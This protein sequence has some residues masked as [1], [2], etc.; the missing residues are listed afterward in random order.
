MAGHSK[1]ANIQHRKGRQDEKR[2]KVWT[3]VIREIKNAETPARRMHFAAFIAVVE[4]LPVATADVPGPAV[5]TSPP[6][7]QAP[8]TTPS[9]TPPP[10]ASR[11]RRMAAR[12]P[13][14]PS[15]PIRIPVLGWRSRSTCRRTGSR[16]G[17]DL[18]FVRCANAI[19][20]RWRLSRADWIRMT[21]GGFRQHSRRSQPLRAYGSSSESFRIWSGKIR[22]P[23]WMC[24]STI[25]C[26]SSV[27]RG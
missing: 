23:R 16:G 2:G 27:H 25:P 1:W 26:R 4:V 22:S 7:A 15:S 3:R 6:A 10:A 24:G 5:A 17:N 20:G 12:W 21:L 9:P 8:A 13:S 14:A 11:S 18:R 19:R